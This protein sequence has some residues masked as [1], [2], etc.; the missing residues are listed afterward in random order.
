MRTPKK[1]TSSM[2]NRGHR[3]EREN[4]GRKPSSSMGSMGKIV[5]EKSEGAVR[6]LKNAVRSIGN[7]T[8]LRSSSSMRG[9]K[10]SRT[11]SRKAA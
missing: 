9:K 4:V 5:E 3:S 2:R 6:S 8:G 1:K 11:S 10:T 7:K